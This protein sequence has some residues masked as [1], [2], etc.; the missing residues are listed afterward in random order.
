[1]AALASPELS[2]PRETVRLVIRHLRTMCDDRCAYH[3][4]VWLLAG[5]T[6]ASRLPGPVVPPSQDGKPIGP[7]LMQIEPAARRAVEAVV[8]HKFDKADRLWT[9]MV[10][11]KKARKLLRARECDPL[12]M[13]VG[14]VD[15]V[16]FW[17]MNCATAK[18]LNLID[19]LAWRAPSREPA[20]I[21]R[22]LVHKLTAIS[23]M[24]NCAMG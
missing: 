15:D 1:V 5:M 22:L 20:A 6:K 4:A 14:A 11:R 8:V 10:L 24:C 9:S 16:A 13:L 19:T 21:A 2:L 12:E 23:V 18:L 17:Q 3:L 7:F